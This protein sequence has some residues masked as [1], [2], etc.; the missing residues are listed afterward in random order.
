V[1]VTHTAREIFNPRSGQRMRFLRTAADTDGELLQIETINPPTGIAEP[2]HVHPRQE[3]RAEIVSGT[4]R[5]VVNGEQRRLGPGEA[6]TIPAGAPHHFVNDGETDAVAIQEARPALRTAEFF[7]TY[8][9]LA[10]RGELDEHGKPSLLRFAV[11]G[12]A[13]ADE[14]RLTSPPWP[15]QR[16]VFGLLAPIARLRGYSAT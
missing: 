14:I 8:F 7:E 9:G 12:P 1:T 15:V 16:A 11:L 6:I 3:T 10:E 2:M 5:F 13:F 4:L